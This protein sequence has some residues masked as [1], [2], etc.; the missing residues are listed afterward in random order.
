M[1]LGP[2]QA[3]RAELQDARLLCEQE[4]LDEEIL[5]FG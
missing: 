2:I 5:Q 3:N 1:H 4:H